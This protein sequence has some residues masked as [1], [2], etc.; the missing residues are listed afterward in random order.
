MIFG[1]LGLLLYVSTW[2]II[3][4]TLWVCA[5]TVIYLFLY[6]RLQALRQ[7]AFDARSE[8]NG[9]FFDDYSNALTV[10]LYGDR[11][12][13]DPHVTAA[14]HKHVRLAQRSHALTWVVEQGTAMLNAVLIALLFT[15]ALFLWYS[16]QTTAGA[17]AMILPLGL[18]ITD[19]A[20]HVIS[21]VEVFTESAAEMAESLGTLAVEPDI[22]DRPQAPELHVKGG[23]IDVKGLNFGH[24][25]QE[26][27]FT[28]M[29]FRIEPGESVAL[30]G[31]SGAGKS[32]IAALFPRLYDIDAGQILIDGQDIASVGLQSLR[33]HI[34]FVAQDISLFHRSVADNIRYGRP[35]ATDAE[36]EAPAKNAE[37]HDFILELRDE[38]GGQGYNATVGER[39]V[40]LSGGQRQRISLARALI[41]DAPI[42]ILDEATASLD[43]ASEAR[44][45]SNLRHH[46]AGR[47][48]V[49]I[50]HRLSTIRD[51]DRIFVIAR[52]A[53]TETGRHADLVA[54]DGL[55]AKL[56]R[57]QVSDQSGAF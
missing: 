14:V 12:R 53:I 22:I 42:L 9:V 49:A 21:V 48:V 36:V 28:D 51:F 5:V 41:K 13:E 57:R 16:G 3:P 35:D 26:L 29:D 20:N 43:S 50:A 7:R 1:S 47:T 32:S 40:K 11:V 34:A 55:Y 2:L 25:G 33:D 39:G 23:G 38:E 10:Q 46:A 44:I 19:L 6:P 54:Q 4:V 24:P 30:V 37:A 18:R 31:P 56:W 45:L 52:G 15:I 27:L 8:M 17:V